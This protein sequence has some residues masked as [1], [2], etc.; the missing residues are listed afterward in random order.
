MGCGSSTVLQ[1]VQDTKTKE[2][3][4]LMEEEK[5][6]AELHFKLLC[7]GAGESGKSTIIKQ[8]VFLHKQAQI[9]DEEKHAYVRV[10]HGNVLTCI[11]TLIKEASDFGYQQDE[12]SAGCVEMIESF[13]SRQLLND[14]MVAAIEYLWLHSSAIAKTYERRAEFWLLESA[15]YYFQHMHRFVEEDYSPSEEDIVAARKRTTGVVETS[16]KYGNVAWSVV[17]VGGQRSE[18][19]KWLNCFDDVQGILFTENLAGYCSVL[20]E[21]KNVNRM[22]ESLKLFEDTMANP[23]FANTPVFLI[24]N[25]KD[26]FEQLI[27]TKP[28][29]I[30]FPEYTGPQQLRPCIEYIAEQFAARL[31]PNHSKPMVLLMAAR[32]KKDVQYCFEDVKDTLLDANRKGIKKAQA[33][34]ESL[35]EKYREEQLK[36]MEAEAEKKK[37]LHHPDRQAQ[38]QKHLEELKKEAANDKKQKS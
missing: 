10:L 1:P 38:E 11:T 34:L 29:T 8:L 14:S 9:S 22:Q 36:E 24:L 21:D 27:E 3:D 18:R 33:K 31:P 2:F 5:V 7:L 4:R 23:L 16:L 12:K 35:R 15:A 20:F 26:L 32:V 6:E 25:K 30:A 19:R 17:D 37:N 13:D 28:L